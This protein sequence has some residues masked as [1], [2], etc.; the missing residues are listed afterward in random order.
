MT[1]SNH[2]F[3][4]FSGQKGQKIFGQ[5]PTKTDTVT[6]SSHKKQLKVVGSC[7]KD[8]RGVIKVGSFVLLLSNW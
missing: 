6:G 3:H 2:I 8:Y 5:Y 7:G 4:G 1:D